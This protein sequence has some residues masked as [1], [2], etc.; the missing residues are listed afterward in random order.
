[1]APVGDGGR[2]P[3][4]G[5]PD[6]DP[7]IC[8]TNTERTD[9][10]NA[11]ARA[12]RTEAAAS[13]VLNQIGYPLAYS[14]VIQ[15]INP[16]QWWT[17]VFIEFDNGI[18]LVPF[19]T[20]LYNSSERYPANAVF[21]RLAARHLTSELNSTTGETNENGRTAASENVTAST[22]DGG[23]AQATEGSTAQSAEAEE[24]P[25]QS[26]HVIVRASSEP[27]RRKAAEILA[28][29]GL[30]PHE[31][32]STAHAVS[33][34]VNDEDTGRVR[35]RLEETDLGWTVVPAGEPD[36]PVDQPGHTVRSV[37][38]LRIDLTE[39]VGQRDRVAGAEEFKELLRRG[40]RLALE[41]R[42]EHPDARDLLAGVQ[43]HQRETLTIFRE[44]FAEEGL[45]DV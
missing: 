4:D 34:R 39:L 11:V 14:P 26:C 44:R 40:Q 8:L 16:E 18:I 15:G 17:Q 29:L 21:Q 25:A 20:L 38:E 3:S 45:V 43:Q 6:G 36:V 2:S 13:M 31:F 33:Y 1:M 27:E 35:E 5:I 41:L 23:R 22:Q 30:G 10:L 19:R 37:G 42:R 28:S 9:F 24:G 12:Y 7:D 32:W